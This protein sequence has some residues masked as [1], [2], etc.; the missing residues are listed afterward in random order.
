MLDSYTNDKSNAK[1]KC[2]Y[3]TCASINVKRVL[4]RVTIVVRFWITAT[5]SRSWCRWCPRYIQE[6]RFGNVFAT[7]ADDAPWMLLALITTV[8][9]AH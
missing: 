3:T 7:Q 5:Q 8:F 4:F 1:Q 9:V 6:V 2:T